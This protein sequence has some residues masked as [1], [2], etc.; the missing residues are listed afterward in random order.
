MKKSELMDS[1]RKEKDDALQVAGQKALQ[2]V[3]RCRTRILTET[4]SSEVCA[5]ECDAIYFQDKAETIQGFMWQLAGLTEL[6]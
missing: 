2:V 4:E 5:L 6:N 3:R 1:L